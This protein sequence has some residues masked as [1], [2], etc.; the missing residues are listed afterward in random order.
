MRTL[1]NFFLILFLC[2]A[3]LAVGDEI[4]SFFWPGSYFS[5]LR[6]F[7]ELFTVL[8]G[9]LVYF[10]FAFNR[11]LPK[12]V[13]LPPLLYL[14]WGLL[15]FWPMEQLTHSANYR[16]Y[17]AGGQLLLGILI[18]QLNRSINRKSLLLVPTQFVG[19][20]FSGR[21]FFRF[22]LVNILVLPTAL[23]LVVFFTASNQLEKQSAGFI[24]LKP[25][26]L[27]MTEKIY[28]RQG[29]TIRLA[30]MIHLGR[31]EYFDDLTNSI[32]SGRTL[33]LAEGV[34]DVTGRLKNRFSY[35]QLA[36]LL[37]LTSQ[38]DIRFYGRLIEA[39]DLD[40]PPPAKQRRPDILLA[41][42]DVQDFD[43]QTIT[44]LDALAKIITSSGSLLQNYQEFNH[45]AADHITPETNRVILQDLIVRRNERVLGFLPQALTNYQTVIIPW[46]ALHMP[47]I[48][49]RLINLGFTL[50][51]RR[52]RQSV[53]FLLLPYERLWGGKP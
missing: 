35:N 23:L 41:D 28:Q 16:L 40:Q 36:D 18:L 8:L 47:G 26:G 50:Q 14:Y 1:A 32:P 24:H 49:R 33:I 22:C 7:C 2:A 37:G 21:R 4:L 45:W 38:E 25:N 13:L 11:H 46:G 52:E 9:V 12:L 42:V 51:D 15:G 3:T 20:G 43:K 31:K 27:Y 5:L 48:E 34:S 19:P 6:H 10:G 39:A 30:A 53:D 17:A 29:R 44:A